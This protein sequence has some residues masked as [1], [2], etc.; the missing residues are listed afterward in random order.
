VCV[1]RMYFN[2]LCRVRSVCLCMYVSVLRSM[3][4]PLSR[5]R[6]QSAFVNVPVMV[7]LCC[8]YVNVQGTIITFVS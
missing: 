2:A 3:K 6:I 5:R 8:V 7:A 1:L 4:G